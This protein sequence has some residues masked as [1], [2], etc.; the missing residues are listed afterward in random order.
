MGKEKMTKP[1]AGSLGIFCLFGISN[2][3][4]IALGGVIILIGVVTMISA[5]YNHFHLIA[6][7]AGLITSIIG[8]FAFCGRRSIGKVTCFII[9]EVLLLAAFIALTVIFAMDILC[10]VEEGICET[11]KKY[12]IKDLMTYFL[13]GADVLNLLILILG[14]CYRGSLVSNN[15]SNINLLSETKE[16]R[17]ARDNIEKSRL[18]VDQRKK[19]YAAKYPEMVK[20]APQY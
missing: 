16:I 12:G 3:C 8:I 9:L 14:V 6:C 15:E 19:E 7:G 2:I 1:R 13:I 4:L 10:K 20:Y 18:S 17:T 11:L 5:G